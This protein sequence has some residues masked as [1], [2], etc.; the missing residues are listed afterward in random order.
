MKMVSSEILA[1]APDRGVTYELLGSLWASPDA[2]L[3]HSMTINAGGLPESWNELVVNSKGVD[4]EL[5]DTE[6]TRLFIGP[7]NHLPPFQSVWQERQLEGEAAAS[8][9]RYADVANSDLTTDDLSTQLLL[10]SRLLF[11]STQTAA[12]ELA[13]FTASYFH[14][15]LTWPEDFLR[16]AANR[17]ELAFF[18]SLSELTREF[19]ADETTRLTIA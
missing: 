6:F 5:L 9:R 8:M 19:L 7:K 1:N 14:A 13:E 15:H 17:A 18:R 16:A 10:M 11:E 2:K 3:L 4:Q 12:P